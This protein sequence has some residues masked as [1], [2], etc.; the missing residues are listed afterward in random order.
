M[1]PSIHVFY[2]FVHLFFRVGSDLAESLCL[3]YGGG[4]EAI[5]TNHVYEMDVCLVSIRD[6]KSV[7]EG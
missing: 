7:V 2:Q 1:R 5:R 6:Q 4:L 3:G